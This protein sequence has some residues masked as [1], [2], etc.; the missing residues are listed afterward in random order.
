VKVNYWLLKSE[1]D[2]FSI[3]HL[4]KDQVTAWEGVRNYQ[5]RNF[6]M[7]EMK[8]G[9]L[10]FFYHS[11]AEPSGIVGIMRVKS[12]KAHPDQTALDKKN[13][14]HD[15]KAT[16]EKPIWYC[17]DFEFVEK[18]PKIITLEDLRQHSTLSEMQVLKKG[19][20]LSVQPVTQLEFSYIQK[21]NVTSEVINV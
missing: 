21:L 17:A 19:Q 13:E 3:D 5:A 15:P 10:A 2:V 14:Y 16:P 11:N 4:Q 1:P 9:D 8:Q 7:K 12:S 6:M 20:R 18:F